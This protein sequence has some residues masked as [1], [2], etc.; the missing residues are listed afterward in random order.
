M[1]GGADDPGGRLQQWEQ[2]GNKLREEARY[3]EAETVL[4]RAL[5]LAR[6]TFGEGA[7]ET[8]LARNSLGIVYKYTGQFDQ[9]EP[10]YRDALRSLL[11]LHGEM[12]SS[13]AV[14]Y[15]NIGGLAHA[16]GDFAAGEAPARR[17]WEINRKLLGEDHPTTL[18][19]AAAFA[20]VLDGLGRYEE[21]EP[22]YRRALKVFEIAGR[23]S[24]CTIKEET[25]RVRT[26]YR[27]RF[28]SR[29]TCTAPSAVRCK[30]E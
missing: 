22:I 11:A 8:P 1:T 15:H 29:D 13:V 6:S 17:T 5:E 21:S 20:G 3:A 25:I 26:G 19:D 14:L 9:A 30:C 28:A 4:K 18:A 23:G 2:I 10:R 24:A 27:G 16:R 12:H 7:E